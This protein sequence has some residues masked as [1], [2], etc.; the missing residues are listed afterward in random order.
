MDDVFDDDEEDEA[1]AAIEDDGGIAVCAAE[2][3]VSYH[4][5]PLQNL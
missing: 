2:I 3:V 1:W 4:A 5:L